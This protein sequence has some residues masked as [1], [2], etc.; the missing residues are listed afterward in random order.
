MGNHIL[1]DVYPDLPKTIDRSLE[2]NRVNASHKLMMIGALR[3]ATFSL[4]TAQKKRRGKNS[5]QPGE[6]LMLHSA[7]PPQP[8]LWSSGLFG[9]R[10]LAKQACALQRGRPENV[11]KIL[12]RLRRIFSFISIGD[13]EKILSPWLCG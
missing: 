11:G 1:T 3:D 10:Q 8:K 12:A 2:S 7:A 9:V 4:K 5:F 13:T 6:K